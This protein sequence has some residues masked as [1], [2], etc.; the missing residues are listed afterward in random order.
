[1][2]NME[3][4]VPAPGAGFTSN[5]EY[6]ASYVDMIYLRAV[7]GGMISFSEQ[8]SFQDLLGSKQRSSDYN[9]YGVN[10]RAEFMEKLRDLKKHL[11]E[12]QKNFKSRLENSDTSKFYLERIGREYQLSRQEI[13]ILAASYATTN[14]SRFERLGRTNGFNSCRCDEVH[15]MLVMLGHTP[16]AR[17][18]LKPFFGPGSRLVLSGLINLCGCATTE[19]D[20]LRQDIELSRRVC[21]QIQG[22]TEPNDAILSFAQLIRPDITLDRVVYDE[23][24]K[25]T[26]LNLIKNHRHFAEQRKH[27]NLDT[28]I[29]YG[30]GTT[31]LFGGSPGTGKTLMAQALANECNLQLMRVSVPN[32]FKR[33]NTEGNFQTVMQEASLQE[34]VLL[35]FDEADEL[36]SDRN[37]NGLMPMIL[38]EFERFSGVCILATNRK[39]LLDEAMDRRILY[40]ADFE[41]PNAEARKLIWKQHLPAELPLADDVDID[42]LARKFTFSGGYI[43][44]AVILACHRLAANMSMSEKPMIHQKDLLDAAQTQRTS[45]LERLTERVVP[46]TKLE[47]VILDP[48]QKHAVESI[49][50]E[51][52]NRDTVFGKWGFANIAP[53]GRG[54][55]ALLYGPSGSGKTLTANAIAHELGLNLVN[56]SANHIVSSYVGESARRIHELFERAKEEEAVILFDECESLFSARSTENGHNAAVN[57]DNNQQIT[58]LLREIENFDGIVLL[59]SN[60][61][62]GD[63]MD[64]AFARRIRHHIHFEAPDKALR[65]AIWKKHFPAEAPLAANVDFEK[66]AD[67]FEF[68]GGTIKQIALKAAFEAANSNSEITQE[69]LRELCEFELGNN[70]VGFKKKT[71]PIGLGQ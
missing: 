56:V 43:K 50:A 70:M 51:Y 28:L 57:R 46:N 30:F 34:D 9:D 64:K 13:D 54:T 41:T 22:V 23:G 6:L 27:W 65:T 66:L 47:D 63:N 52:R 44:N 42:E 32:L 33:G 62:I 26:M 29:G 49:I 69:L 12:A 67:E 10:T 18:K 68:S 7:V 20:F 15:D 16:A 25:K 60:H 48:E 61:I 53:Y 5:E 24:K 37:M 36:F 40:K 45:Q 39:Q 31:L 11:L 19:N 2:S 3:G 17:L 35:F 14:T 1:M 58:V 38:K 8:T 55:I 21:A 59:T 4:T 71:K